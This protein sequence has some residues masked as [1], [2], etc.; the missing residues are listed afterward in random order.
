[1]AGV[2]R[3]GVDLGRV[4]TVCGRVLGPGA[5]GGVLADSG[6]V[7]AVTVELRA[8]LIE[9]CDA[10]AELARQGP[11][12]MRE[13]EYG[14]RVAREARWH[15]ESDPYAEGSLLIRAEH[16]RR[17]ARTCRRL[18]VTCR[19]LRE[20]AARRWWVEITG[21]VLGLWHAGPAPGWNAAHCARLEVRR[22]R[23]ELLNKGYSPTQ[24]GLRLGHVTVWRLLPAAPLRRPGGPPA[25]HTAAG[26]LGAWPR[27]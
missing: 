16:A 27:T 12:G 8:L 23:A 21:P 9:L 24:L 25:L 22:H 13:R 19:V 7:L 20:L 1:M 11:A 3:G 15:L 6:R 10:V 5:P 26:T 2:A 18:A 4:Q 17:L 14:E